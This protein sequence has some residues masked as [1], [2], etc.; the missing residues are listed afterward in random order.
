MKNH[1]STN[2]GG[3]SRSGGSRQGSSD[4]AN[5]KTHKNPRRQW[6]STE[7]CKKPNNVRKTNVSQR[8]SALRPPMQGKK[9][10]LEKRKHL[11]IYLWRWRGRKRVQETYIDTNGMQ[12]QQKESNSECKRETKAKTRK[13]VW[14]Y[15]WHASKF[16]VKKDLRMWLKVKPHS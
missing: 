4:G 8:N 13:K 5:Q 12:M 11:C 14:N 1:G 7:Q 3:D 2:N 16:R 15:V 9:H 10:I 6:K